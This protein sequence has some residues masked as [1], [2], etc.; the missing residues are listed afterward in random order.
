MKRRVLS[1]ALAAVMA[2]SLTACGGNG[3]GKETKKAE[4]TKAVETKE[5]GSEGA[6]TEGSG[7]PIHVA[8]IGPK[9]GNNAFAGE[10]LFNSAKMVFDEYN[11][12]G[13][14][15]G[16]LIEYDEYDTKADANEG[17]VIAQ[18]LA[19]DDSVLATIGPWSSTVGLAMAPILDK[20]EIIMYA[21]SPSHADLTKASKWIIRQSPVAECLAKGCA[22]TLAKNG[23]MNGVYLYDNTNEGAVSGSTMFEKHFKNNGGT[24]TLEGYAAGNKDFTPIL[25]K[26]KDADIDFICMY[27]ATA[28]SALICT[29]ARDLDINC[30]IQVNSMALNDEFNSL[31]AGLDDI[32]C[33]DSYAADYPSDELKA[34]VDT[35]ESEFGKSPI[36]HGYLAYCAAE[37]F[38]EA[39]D[40]LGPDDKEALRAY[41]RDGEQET[42]L[43]TLTFV[44]G[45]ADR[46]TVWLKYDKDASAFKAVTEI[47]ANK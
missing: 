15:K 46:P 8:V 19:A 33:C 41:L 3:G 21:T 38:C 34:Y 36:V 18:K 9:T 7:D 1:I 2:L 35:Y 27:G 5:A 29:Q 42:A 25:T 47:P 23:Y 4:D 37:R 22:E 45:D 30:L 31:I 40:K 17:I 44:D 11:K 43:G 24:V 26:Y 10:Y 14:Y 13:G 6:K 20:A 28:D 12:N 16:R 39:I 32:Y